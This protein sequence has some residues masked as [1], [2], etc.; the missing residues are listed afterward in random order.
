MMNGGGC[1]NNN[2]WSLCEV[3]GIGL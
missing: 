3:Q 1:G 2:S